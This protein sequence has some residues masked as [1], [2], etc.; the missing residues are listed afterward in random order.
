[1]ATQEIP[2]EAAIVLRGDSGI[3]RTFGALSVDD[4]VEQT[5]IVH[6]LMKR[7]M[8][9]GTHYGTIP[10]CGTKQCLLK[11]GAETIAFVLRLAP[12]FTVEVVPLGGEHREV[13]VVCRLRS[14]H[15]GAFVAEGVGSCSTMESKYRWRKG[16]RSCPECGSDALKR[17]KYAPKGRPNEKPGWYCYAKAGGCGTE[18]SYDDER[19]A[20]QVSGRVENPDIADT[21]NTVLKMAKKRAYVDGTITAAAA[22]DV[23]T[24]DV[25]DDEQPDAPAFEPRI[26]PHNEQRRAAPP[27][28]VAPDVKEITSGEGRTRRVLANWEALIAADPDHALAYTPSGPHAGEPLSERASDAELR[29]LLAM[30]EK[31][32]GSYWPA[33]IV[34]IRRELA[35]R[36]S[37]EPVPCD[38]TIPEFEREEEGE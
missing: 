28:P 6:D 36:A 24:Q 32:K 23:F 34:G 5:R 10:G 16:G 9:D 21:Y 7:V 12:E 26:A 27:A 35:R 37:S 11:A 30:A 19:I 18:F 38:D 1:M 8:V 14:I 2:R 22:S 4:V 20:E 13:R 3:Q 33:L 29:T 25:E 31:G 17:S 15:T